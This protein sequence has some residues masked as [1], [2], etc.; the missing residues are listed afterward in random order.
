MIYDTPYDSITLPISQ[1]E[2]NKRLI[3]R[4]QGVNKMRTNRK[5]NVISFY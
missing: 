3:R 1:V 4:Y 2:K 5:K